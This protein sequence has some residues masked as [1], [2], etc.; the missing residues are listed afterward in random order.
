MAATRRPVWPYRRNHHRAEELP[1]ASS[2]PAVIGRDHRPMT[3]IGAAKAA[4]L[5]GLCSI[6]DSIHGRSLLNCSPYVLKW[7]NRTNLAEQEIN[8]QNKNDG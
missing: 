4:V 3:A 5:A 7:S 1:P 2:G 8:C 6:C